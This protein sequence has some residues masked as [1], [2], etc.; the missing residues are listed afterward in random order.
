MP[1]HLSPLGIIH[2]AISILAL[3]VAFYCLFKDGKI[4]PSNDRGKLYIVLT[5]VTCITG[6][7]IMRTGHFTQ[8]HGLGILVLILLPL[9]MYANY[10]KAFGKAAKYFQVA[11]MST[12]LFLSFVPA[13]VETLT[14]LP[15]SHPIATGPNDM[16]VQTG[17]G[18]LFTSYIIGLIYQ[19]RKL[20]S[21]QQSATSPNGI[22]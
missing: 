2:T 15:I 16:P 22:V 17:L 18:I 19:F 3:L 4:L 8:A 9:G 1:N 12:T 13:I 6:F 20:R 7:P 14:R 21:S 5:A 11:I 10:I